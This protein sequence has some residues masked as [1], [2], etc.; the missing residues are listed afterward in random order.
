MADARE[1]G[2]SWEPMPYKQHAHC[3]Q[4]ENLNAYVWR[5]LDLPKFLQLLYSNSLSFARGDQF[6]DP[7]EGMPSDEYIESVRMGGSNIGSVHRQVRMMHYYRT[8]TYINCW[9]MSEHESAAMWKL[10]GGLDAGIAIRSTYSRLQHAFNDVAEDVHLGL[11]QYGGESLF[12]T[13][14]GIKFIMNKRKS[15]EHETEVRTFLW[16]SLQERPADF[17]S[18]DPVVVPLPSPRTPVGIQIPVDLHKLITAVI[19]SPTAPKWLPEVLTNTMKRYGLE[20]TA[21]M[22]NLHRLQYIDS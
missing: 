5:F 17:D 11:V 15:F 12:G 14:N 8:C 22:S 4:P 6:D 13:L 1:L 18:D 3:P 16:R 10:Y 7:Y 20:I 2:D 19:L 21:R 9:H